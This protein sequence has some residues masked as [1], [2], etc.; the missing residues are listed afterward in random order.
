[1]A[2]TL[3]AQ[4]R[5]TIAEE[6]LLSRGDRVVVAV[7]GGADSVT[8]LHL[9]VQLRST[10]DLSLHVAH[11]D[12][13]LRGDS[14][15]DAEFVR[16]LAE[17]HHLPATIE[18]QPVKRI[19]EEEGWSLEDGARRIRYRFLLGA[20][21]RQSASRVALAHTAD[22]QAETVLLRL[23]RGTGLMGLGAIPVSRPLDGDGEG[24]RL[25]RPLL[26]V[27]RRDVTAHLKAHGL[28]WR[29]DATNG[30][31][32]FLRNRVRHELLPLLERSYNGNVKAALTQL[33]EQ[34]RW[35]Y[36]YLEEAALRQWKRVAKAGAPGAPVAISISAFSRQPKALQRQVL[37][38]AIRR[39]RGEPSQVEYRH[40]LEAQRLFLERPVGTLLDLPGRIQ[41]RRESDRVVCRRV[42][43]RP[44]ERYTKRLQ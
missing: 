24:I 22:D 16:S 3:L 41:L 13:A 21:E 44:N 35:D 18:R 26:R 17:R 33:A 27:W 6:R 36:A 20:A 2:S 4:V 10:L 9:L 40:W 34:S 25:I 30:D 39:V 23:V 14:G 19:C 43:G 32:R 28:S 12:H 1:M 31:P 15:R 29:E 5:R 11:L 37:R 42:D 38:S 7:S 8:L